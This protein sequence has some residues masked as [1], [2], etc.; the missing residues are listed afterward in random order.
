MPAPVSATYSA[1][2]LVAATTAFRDLIDAGVGAG[3]IRVRSSTDVLLAE[4]PLQ[5]PCGTV[6]G[7][8]GRLTL[9]TDGR[10]EE[11][12][13][14][15]VAAYAEVCD[16]AGLVHLALPAQVG[17][18]A[19]SGFVVLNTTTIVLGGPVEIISATVG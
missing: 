2:A 10:D 7:T 15:G 13:A 9:L 12:A 14:D 19:V 17:A 4:I 18:S 3:L 1:A 8:T 16:S 6:N 5:D 11:A